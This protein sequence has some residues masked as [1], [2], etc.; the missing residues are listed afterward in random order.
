M[1]L[2]QQPMPLGMARV[3]PLSSAVRL[4]RG[5]GDLAVILGHE[6]AG[7]GGLLLW[8]V[9]I[10]LPDR[11]PTW[12]EI[13]DVRYLFPQLARVTMAQLLPPAEDYVSVH[14]NCFHLWEVADL[15]APEARQ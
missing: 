13:R 5:P 1:K 4:Y 10:S 7:P 12:D 2:V 6:P 14:P 9:S 15:R 3:L 11:Y 8:H